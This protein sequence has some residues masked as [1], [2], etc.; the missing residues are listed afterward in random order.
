MTASLSILMLITL[1]IIKHFIFDF[2][3][4][5]HYMLVNKGTY[6]HLGG[7][8][9]SGLHAVASAIVVGFFYPS[10]QLVFALACLEFMIHYHMDWIKT[11]INQAMN[12]TPVQNYYWWLTGLDQ[13]VHYMTYVLIVI[14]AE[15]AR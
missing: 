7:I 4:Q 12:W 5:T 14:L 8:L 9:H 3:L 10:F 1:L 13:F 2:V 6:G 15:I 11:N